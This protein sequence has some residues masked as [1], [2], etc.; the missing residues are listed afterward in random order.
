M[1]K[2][3]INLLKYGISLGIIAWLVADARSNQTFENLVAQPKQWDLL[4][5]AWILGMA[6]VVLTI[7]RWYYLVRA[8]GLPFTLKDAFR[9]GFLGYLLNFVSLGAVGG[10]L[11]K[12]IFIAREQRGRR[13]EAV[14]SVVV[15]RVIG[16][17]SLFLLATSAILWHNQLATPQPEI[18]RICWATVVLTVVGGLGV[19]MMLVPGFTQGALSEMLAG[20][21]RVGP[22]FDRLIKAI[23][24]YRRR[25]DVIAASLAM[26]IGTHVLFTF[27]LYSIARGLPGDV[28]SLA[29]HF[30]AVPLAMVSGVLPLPM[31]GLGA[32]EFVMEYLY[33]NLAAAG[34]DVG[35]QGLVV[36]LAYR[37]ITIVIAMAGVVIYLGSRRQVSEVLHEAEE[38]TLGHHDHDQPS[39]GH[40]SP[41]Q[42]RQ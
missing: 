33:G 17:Y 18:R 24:M 13:A 9:L 11:F 40:A 38:E 39:A 3:V 8:L 16:L 25:L 21:P 28:P 22:I 5:L 32:F 29:D 1:K 42:G 37:V 26:S 15:D 23:R 4:A 35:S 6:A 34:T 27:C 10:D 20:L 30:V 41:V 31:N 2:L 12:A 14:A 19:A 36:A 7:V